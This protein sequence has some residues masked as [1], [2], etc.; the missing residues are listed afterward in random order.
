MTRDEAIKRVRAIAEERGTV[1]R[2][3]A[4]A[5]MRR[6]E[7]ALERWNEPVFALGFD[8]GFAAAIIEAFEI[9]REDLEGPPPRGDS[10][11]F[12]N[13]PGERFED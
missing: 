13:L 1:D 2:R 5:V 6:G 11:R 8:Y 10:G 7:R 9:T 4:A 12:Y 3:T